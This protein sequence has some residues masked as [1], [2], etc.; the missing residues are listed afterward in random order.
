MDGVKEIPSQFNSHD[1]DYQGIVFVLDALAA[2]ESKSLVVR[3]NS[4]GT[5]KH[6]YTKRTQAE[7]SRKE[8]GKI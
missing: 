6:S 4:T 2:K 1:N 7:L 5:V 8:G 3:Y